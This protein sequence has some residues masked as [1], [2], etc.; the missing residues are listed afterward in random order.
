MLTQTVR[1]LAPHVD[2]TALRPFVTR[3]EL[4]QLLAEARHH[5]FASVCLPPCHVAMAAAAL[6]NS[7]VRVG[8]VAGFPLGFSTTDAKRNELIQATDAGAHE[9]DFVMNLS[10]FRSGEDGYVGDEMAALAEAAHARGAL[11]KCILETAYLHDDEVVAACRLCAAAGVDYAKTSTGYA[12]EG[13]RVATVYLMR[14]TLPPRVR[15]K[16]AG[17]IRTYE[18]ALALLDAGADRLGTSQGVTLVRTDRPPASED[19][20]AGNETY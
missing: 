2:H 11:V 20:P 7:A 5:G 9:V 13:A 4:D 10:M 19:G 17:G 6:R 3:R 16:A 12:P 8:T 15:I 14:R 1:N 18:Q